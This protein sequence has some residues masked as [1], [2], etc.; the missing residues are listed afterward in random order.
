MLRIPL[1]LLQKTRI[2][3]DSFFVY[4]YMASAF[5]LTG[6]Y[7]D[8]DQYASHESAVSACDSNRCHSGS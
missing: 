2:R 8:H 6:M 3:K 4:R 1:S 5:F 7:R